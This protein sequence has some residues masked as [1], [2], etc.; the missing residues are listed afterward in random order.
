MKVLCSVA[1]SLLVS[2][3]L[4]RAETTTDEVVAKARQY[5]GGDAALDAIRSISYEATFTSAD[6]SGGEMRII[7]QKPLQQRVEVIRGELGEISALNDLDGWRKVYDLNDSS[8]WSI[9]LLDAPKVRELQA[10]TWENLSFFKG[11]ER[12]RG[13]I[14]N[15]GQSELDGR[16]AVELIFHYS[17]DLTFVRFFDVETGRLLMTRTKDGAEIRESGNIVVDGVIFPE[18]IRM[19]RDGELLNEI[20]FTRITVNEVFDESLFDVPPLA[21]VPAAASTTLTR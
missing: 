14:E 7:F 10:N 12:R 11:I 16:R 9:T 6:G 4:V 15:K 3:S 13:W 17:R 18:T 1:L 20:K 8:R 19:S 2:F 21:P 5:L